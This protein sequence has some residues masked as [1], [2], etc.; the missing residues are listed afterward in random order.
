M[1][2]EKLWSKQVLYR[3]YKEGRVTIPGFHIDYALT[4]EACL[5]LYEST[6]DKAWLELALEL[7]ETSMDKFY[8]KASGMFRYSA[9]DTEVLITHHH[10]IQDNVIPSSNSVMANSL[11]RLGQL[12]VKREYVEISTKMGK[13]MSSQFGQYPNGFAG[14]GRLLLKQLHHFLLFVLLSKFIFMNIIFRKT[15]NIVP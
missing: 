13:Q 2:K 11:F 10:E 8:D 9:D 4:I 6:M 5:D 7:T 12:L 3:N 1:I 15:K 14:W